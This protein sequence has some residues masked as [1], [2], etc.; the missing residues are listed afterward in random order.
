MTAD[1]TRQRL[2]A[3]TVE[4]AHA[5]LL[6]EYD[7]TASPV[8]AHVGFGAF[9]RA[10]LAV[11]ADELQ[12]RG[13][14]ALIRGVT[15]RSPR[16]QQ[17]LDPQDGLF[18]VAV[19]EPGQEMALQVV[20]ALSSMSTG[21]EAALNAM[22]AP[23][24]ELVTVTITEKGY[25]ES[26]GA[27]SAP[28][29]IASAL[30]RRRQAGL[31]P[32]VVASLDNLADNGGVLR[33]RVLEAAGAIDADLAAY[34]AETVRFPS[35]VVDRMVPA[36]TD[37][38]RDAIAAALGLVDEAAVATEQHRSWVMR[39]VDGLEYLAE[40]GVALVDDVAPFERRKLWLLNGPHSATAYAGLLSGHATI[41]AAI[42]DPVVARFVRDLV[43]R[44]LEV[45]AFPDALGAR[46]FA[47]DTLR[48]FANPALGHTCVQVGADGSSKLPQRLLPVVAARQAQG[49]DTTGF[50]IVGAIWLAAT[51]GLGVV[52]ASLPRVEDPIAADLGTVGH[53]PD[54]LD[55]LGRRAFGDTLFAAEV[56]AM[57]GRLKK[58]G[59]RVLEA[60][61]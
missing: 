16:A 48:R 44:T 1:R 29:L 58:E 61:R 3:R 6:P 2:D 43:D 42:S 32:P 49:L 50:A 54:P 5:A 33:S 37:D 13:H 19:R 11:Y 28:A 31:R 21:A 26:D 60:E 8:I 51:T 25:G 4:R 14:P 30:S 55:G 27:T 9:A 34:V 45:A 52:G 56:A 12:R 10:H 22:T 53:G 17:Q 7:R 24:I 39:A 36:P 18:T 46:P 40:A 57:L 23:A 38:D 59:A 47:V 20:G 15:L 35:S 41:A